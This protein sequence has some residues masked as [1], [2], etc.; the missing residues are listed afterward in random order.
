MS[1]FT[2]KERARCRNN[3]FTLVRLLAAYGVLFA[4]SYAL[5]TG[6][7][8][9]DP[10]TAFIHVWWGQGL[11]T[12]AVVTFFVISG[13]LVS[14]SYIHRDNLFVFTEARCLRI[15]P[16]LFVAVFFCAFV[17]GPWVTS[18][19]LSEYFSHRGTWSFVWHNVTL[20]GGIH[21]RLP[22]VFL[23]NPWSG[24][25]NGSLWTLPLELY[26]YCMVILIGALG[27]LKQRVS[28][29]A[30]AIMLCLSLFALQHG[31]VHI[32]GLP[33]KYATLAMAYLAGVIF[34][35]NREF[36]SLNTVTLAL[37][38]AAMFLLYGTVVWPVAQVFG[39]A[40]I[41]LFI[42]LHPAITLPSMDRW[43]DYSYGVYIYAF[44]VQQL[45]V[46]YLSTSPL[47]VLLYTTL[48]TLPLAILSWYF[49]EK[50]ALRLKG[51]I[52]MGQKWLDPRTR[53]EPGSD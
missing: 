44:P 15:F 28:F 31:W 52:Q 53:T 11:G 29:N 33:V 47:E 45:V 18:F 41:I 12:V 48:F 13:F 24:G 2:I 40:Y 36:I 26:M 17:V 4:H 9:R 37:V 20:L 1:Y 34:Y 19:P 50:P 43:G 5:A 38:V 22:G 8:A 14:A 35:V 23:D 42:S 16:A 21:F 46:K 51:K 32:D 7:V 6:R 39:F 49:I 25:V 30:V 3:N 10:V 27:I